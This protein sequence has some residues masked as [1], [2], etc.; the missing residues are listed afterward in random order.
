MSVWPLQWMRW[1]ESVDMAEAG[2]IV[3]VGDKAAAGDIVTV[4]DKAAG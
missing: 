4:G 3:T 1:P 2:D